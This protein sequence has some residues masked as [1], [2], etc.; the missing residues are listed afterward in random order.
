MDLSE[1]KI[2]V[3]TYTDIKYLQR[4]LLTI[5][6]I[7]TSGQYMGDL[8]VMTDGSF[9]FQTEFLLATSII[10]KQY[11]DV[12]VKNLVEKIKRHPF[13][14]SDRRE[15]EKTKQWNKLFSFDVWFKQWDY[16]MFVDAGLRIFDRLDYFFLQFKDSS[17]VAMDDS[18]PDDIKRFDGQLELS[19]IEVVDK[20]K[21]IHDIHSR[22]FLN[23]LFL[24]D[25][26]LITAT[27]MTDLINLMNEYP[28]C[29][30][31]EMGIMNIYFAKVWVPLQLQM[32]DGRLLF[33][34]CERD[35]KNW[36]RYVAV[37][38]SYTRHW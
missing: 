11:P 22:Y 19:N 15:Y 16:V 5:K 1:K 10:V 35:G 31:N 20:L 18:H 33:D 7:R 32:A 24:Y 25:T 9:E 28:I 6:D 2:C 8:V 38:Y 36:D 4:A 29:R 12:D 3:V 26:K 21:K 13:V 17:I 37:K 23:C 14:N 34:W 30:T 27:T